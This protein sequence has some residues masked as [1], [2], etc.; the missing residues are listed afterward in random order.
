MPLQGNGLS[1]LRMT[2]AARSSRHAGILLTVLIVIALMTVGSASYFKWT[3]TEHQATQMFG[4]HTQARYASESAVEYLRVYLAQDATDIETAGGLYDNPSRFRGLTLLDSEAAALRCRATIL[5]PN[6]DQGEYM[7][8]RFGLENE[9]SRL[10]LNTLLLIDQTT[11]N[12]ARER[13]LYLPGMT[14]AIADAILDWIDEDDD[15]R[16]FGA[17]LTHYAALQ[18]AYAPQNGPLESLDQLLM[19]RDVTPQLLYGLDRNRDMQ[20]DT[21]EATTALPETV[22][23]SLGQMQR[24][25]AAYLTLYSAEWELNPEGEPKINVNGEDLQALHQEIDQKLGRGAANFIVA[26]RQGGPSGGGIGELDSPGE[27]S[28]TAGAPKSAD[29]ITIDFAAPAAV[30]I[31]NLLSLV[32]VEVA[33]VQAGQNDRET[34]AAEFP[35]DPQQMTTYLPELQDYLTV[36]QGEVAPGR[37]NINQAPRV[38]LEGVPGMPITAVESIISNRDFDPRDDRPGRRHA[39]WPLTEGYVTLDEMRVM[40]PWVTGGGDVFRAQ[41][42]G[43]FDEEGPRQRIE[44]VI[45]ATTDAPRILHQQDLS[46]LGGGPSVAELGS[47]Q[48]IESQGGSNASGSLAK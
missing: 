19:V 8:V 14:E 28:S 39:T 41:I 16:E 31:D 1:M 17:E 26:F 46:P 43:F 29:S 37:L 36:Y 30:T 25:W 6:I 35:A 13:L 33:V 40:A 34:L 38:L 47:T 4:R 27:E 42:I 18:P 24:G 21:T 11:E 48:G 7:G 10:N 12:G 22:N 3:F 5:A 32:G 44:A 15:P 9:S 20:I 45:D 2:S 23:D